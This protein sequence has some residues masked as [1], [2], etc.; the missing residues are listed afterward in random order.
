MNVKKRFVAVVSM[1]IV[2]TGALA[3]ASDKIAP[4]K[5]ASKAEIWLPVK[6]RFS[7]F[8]LPAGQYVLQHRVEGSDHIMTFVQ[9]GTRNHSV[10]SR[11]HGLMPVM[12]RCK[13]E[14]LAAKASETAFYSVAEDGTN[15]AI[16]LEIKGENVAHIFPV[17]TIPE[18]TVQ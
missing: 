17:P 14:P 3:F 18:T 11:T 8:A 4:G 16:K 1:L 9:L 13:L 12:V 5:V 10:S 7:G 2:L 6:T 15:R